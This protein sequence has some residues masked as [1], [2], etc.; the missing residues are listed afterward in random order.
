MM[1]CN[2]RA[3]ID[4]QDV[5][6]EYGEYAY[7]RANIWIRMQQ[8]Q[9]EF[10]TPDGRDMISRGVVY[11]HSDLHVGDKIT[12]DNETYKIAQ[13]YKQRDLVG[14]IVFYKAFLI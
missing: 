14:R 2:T 8:L 7:I 5:A 10:K 12:C 6:N 4:I 1:I 9:T 13:V 3:I 11:S